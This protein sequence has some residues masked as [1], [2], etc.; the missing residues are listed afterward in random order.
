[1]L[2]KPGGWDR[3]CFG[4][5][6]GFCH[7]GGFV[8]AERENEDALRFE[9]GSHTHGDRSTG[10]IFGAEKVT[11]G[12]GASDGVEGNHAGASCLV[13]TGFIEA[14]VTGAA[15]AEDLNVDAA[16]S[17]NAGFVVAAVVGNSF[18]RNG[19]VRDVCL[20][21]RDV[22]VIEEVFPHE[23]HVTL[24]IFWLHRMVFIQ[25]ECDD[26][27]EREAFFA[28]EADQFGVDASGS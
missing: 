21:R 2:L 4:T 6:D 24:H 7:D 25:I 10:D 19:A 9:N 17:S 11:G 26:V 14:D 12:I 28:V 5:F 27:S 16:G 15:D 22:N 1:M 8:F 18:G 20:P 23:S 13:G 3:G